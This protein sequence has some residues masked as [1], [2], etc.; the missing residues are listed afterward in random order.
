[1]RHPL[2]EMMEKRRQGIKIGIPS[3]CTANELVLE[4]ALYRA[5]ALGQPVLIEATANQVNQFGGYTGMKPGDFYRKVLKL[6]EKI[7]VL[8]NQLILAG[9]HLGPLTWQGLAE[10]EAM[11]NAEELVY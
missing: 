8:E 6:A 3:Y 10:A 7:G 1:M 11:K 5:K 9:D 4:I 2:Q